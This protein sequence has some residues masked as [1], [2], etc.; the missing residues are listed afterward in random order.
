MPIAKL[1]RNRPAAPLLSLVAA[2]LFLSPLLSVL[3]ARAQDSGSQ[4][5]APR[6]DR[7]EISVT[8]RDTSGE[9]ITAAGTVK[10]LHEGLPADEAAL[11]K[12][13]AFFGLRNFGN[14]SLV[15]EVT[16][17][18][19][20]QKDVDATVAMRYEVDVNLRRDSDTDQTP[21]APGKPILAPKAKEALDK[22]LKALG[23]NNLSEAEKHVAEAAK[24]AP[25][26]PDVLYVQ[27]VLYL[28]QQKWVQ[29]ES[30]LEKAS[31]MAPT[32]AQVLSALGMAFA[33]EGKYA[34]AIPPLEKS[35]QLGAGT[36]E[37]H[38]TLGRSYYHR[39]QYDKALTT[40]QLAL[41]E[42]NGKAPQI[43]LLVAQSLTAVGKYE[44]AA[45]SLR[46][47]LKRYGD[48]PE[49]PTARR[50][51]DGLAKNGKIHTH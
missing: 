27:G 34:E 5:M 33:D 16:G 22:A 29:A 13:R 42:S 12:G 30:A 31:Q 51:L 1:Y 2:A 39:Q 38:W 32:S 23:E 21:G 35:L 26:H 8:V 41:T 48:R 18:K 36:W 50:W 47:F 10:L 11:T 20:A 24:L 9:P 19:S 43:E 14:Y 37:T 25:G 28:N 49:A 17:Y 44:D 6:T 46:D 4:S 45:Q 40:S 3:S 15:V 7:P